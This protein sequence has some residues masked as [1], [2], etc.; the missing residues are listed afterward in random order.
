MRLGVWMIVA[1]SLVTASVPAL[2]QSYVGTPLSPPALQAGIVAAVAARLL[3]PPAA[4]IRDLAPSLARNGHGY[5]GKVSPDG[6]APFQPFHI[7][8]GEDGSYAVLILPEKG[9]PP[10]LARANA[11]QLLTNFGCL[12]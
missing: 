10:G 6:T 7:I 5:C 8:A 1:A 12:H 3:D 4:H 9:D 2:A 11:V